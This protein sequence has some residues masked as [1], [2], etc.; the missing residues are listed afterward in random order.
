MRST[1]DIQQASALI[2]EQGVAPPRTDL[3]NIATVHQYRIVR[4]VFCIFV[5]VARN[6]GPEVSASKCSRPTF[7]DSVHGHVA[8]AEMLLQLL[9]LMLML[10]LLMS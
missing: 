7:P 6:D 3:L 4:Q 1:N 10:Q 9:M 5:V 2:N 8:L